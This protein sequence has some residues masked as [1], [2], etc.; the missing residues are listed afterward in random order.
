MKTRLRIVCGLAALTALVGL[1]AAAI[2]QTSNGTGAQTGSAPSAQTG[3]LS[4]ADQRF[5]TDAIQ[6][7]LS[8][9]KMGELAQ[10][11]GKSEAAKQFGQMLQQDH[12]QHL[13]K[14]K[15]LAQ[16]SGMVAPSE[17]D[18]KQKSM[19]DRLSKLDGAKFDREFARAMVSDHKEDIAKYKKEAGTKGPL[20]DFAQQTLPTLEKHL[21]T[22][23]DLTHQRS[24]RR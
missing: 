17:P 11:K 4:A 8:E 16:Q 13:D 20:A 18:A 9:I 14:A 5:M 7:D 2:A 6:G 1:T 3:K 21:K 23:E 15:A 19:Y 10:Q 24:S 22:A 12:S